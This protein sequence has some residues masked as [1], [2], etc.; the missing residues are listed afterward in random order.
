MD[1]LVRQNNAMLK[2]LLKNQALMM[3]ILDE[4][5]DTLNEDSISDR[6][7]IERKMNL[8][9]KMAENYYNMFIA[10]TEMAMYE[11]K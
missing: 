8:R 4:A 2:V 10:M 7:Y 6:D 9:E 1:D 5:V 3:V 11:G